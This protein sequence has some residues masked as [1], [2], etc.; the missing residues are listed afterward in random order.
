MSSGIKPT[1]LLMSGRS[2]AFAATFLVPV[3]LVRIFTQSEFGTYKQLFL[4]YSTL[5]LIA[6]CGMAESLFYF[7]P[8][9]GQQGGRYLAN[10]ML[11]LAAAGLG[12][13]ALLVAAGPRLSVWLSNS[14]L[15]RHM[16]WIGLF[17]VLMLISSVLEIAMIARGRYLLASAW[18]GTADMLR[19]AFLVV[20][21]LLVRRID[22]LLIGA[23]VFAALRLVAGVVYIARTFEHDF[24]PDVAVLRRQLLY[25]L[26]FGGAILLEVFQANLHQYAVSYYFDARTFAIYSVGCLQIPFVDLVV[27]SAS[28]VMM[29]RMAERLRE[30]RPGEAAAVWH[31]T[32]RN[33]ALVLIPLVGLLLVTAH[34]LIVILFTAAYAESAPIFMIWSLAILLGSANTDGAL[35]VYADTRFLLVLNAIRLGLVALLVQWSMVRFGLAGA[36]LVTLFATATTKALGLARIARLMQMPAVAL[37]PWRD[38][39][40][41]ALVTAPAALL[42]G[43]VIFELTVP[44]AARLVMASA[45]YV[46]VY[47]AVLWRS[48]VLTEAERLAVTDRVRQWTARVVPN[49]S[50]TSAARGIPPATV[51]EP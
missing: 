14:E 43:L 47:V 31:E 33:L 27:T 24:R 19:A 11:V 32:F 42:A 29:V 51:G 28:N 2:I 1:F 17:L 5:Y 39:G 30:G 35:R 18:Y 16:M 50:P 12:C 46:S 44:L 13:L 21:V 15:S 49:Y 40:I 38:I 8:S 9:A 41:I 4:I 26:P 22:A 34:A 10:S 45:L 25:V 36:V 48:G 6:Q 7:L 23:V 3:V 37:V 20:P